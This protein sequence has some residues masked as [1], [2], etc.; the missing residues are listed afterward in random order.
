MSGQYITP[1][2]TIKAS[3]FINQGAKDGTPS[4]DNGR[5]PLLESV[6]GVDAKLHPNFVY[7]AFGG[8]GSD[9]AL[10]TSGGAVD[11]DLGGNRVVTKN[12]SSINVVT[13][14]VTFSNPHANGTIVI[15]K[16]SGDA[17]ISAT[18]DLKGI[19]ASNNSDGNSLSIGNELSGNQG[20]NVDTQ[21]SG[22]EAGGTSVSQMTS[23][24]QILYSLQ[25]WKLARKDQVI[26]CGSGGGDGGAGLSG[27][28][29]GEGG[30]GGGSIIFECAGDLD[31]TGTIDISGADGNDATNITVDEDLDAAPGGGGGGAA[32]MALI[33]YK[34]ATATS[35]TINNAGGAG[36]DGGDCTSVGSFTDGGGAG[37]GSGGASYAGASG[38][39]GDGGTDTASASSGSTGGNCAGSGGG[40]GA[41]SSGS[42]S[43]TRS[44]GS[45]G[46]VT[47]T[48]SD[49]AV[50]SQ[51]KYFV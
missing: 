14:N 37:G 45:G 13:N 49:G 51:N 12:Y 28:P 17:T 10:D 27:V 40:G 5:V 36:G 42:D 23:Q 38:A 24:N 34:T 18:I 1:G 30:N 43:Q 6:G 46:A 32:G 7:N 25:E 44:G 11:I 35:G 20:G 4:N 19:G 48:S 41:G 26:A 29:G 16:C 3:H 8:D 9:G 47:A 39:G 33:L 2:D 31:F 22:S 50:T 15:F 21:N